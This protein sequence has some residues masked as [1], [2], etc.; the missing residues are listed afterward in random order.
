MRKRTVKNLC[1]EIFWHIVYFLPI[2]IALFSMLLFS[3]ENYASAII[4]SDEVDSN[5][6]VDDLTNTSWVFNE[7]VDFDLYDAD[8]GS[9]YDFCYNIDY[10]SSGEV[11][12]LFGIARDLTAMGG[13]Q[14]YYQYDYNIVYNDIDYPSWVDNAYRTIHITGGA[15]VTNADL[16]NFLLINA[17]QQNVVD[18]SSVSIFSTVYDSFNSSFDLMGLNFDNDI[19]YRALKQVFVNGG[20]LSVFNDISVLLKFA[21]YY[22]YVHIIHLFIDCLLF[23]PKMAHK[24]I[25]KLTGC[26]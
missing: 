21:C 25:D 19:L 5:Q 8:L 4:S 3:T 16:I 15:D 22:F 9:I 6:R 1:K 11:C 24:W 26:E 12:S 10:G 14:L 2:I 7:F 20:I 17:T 23:I 18:N 13:H